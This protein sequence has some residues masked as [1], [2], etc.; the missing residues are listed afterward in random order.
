MT[1]MDTAAAQAFRD[2]TPR[3]RGVCGW[4]SCTVSSLVDAG[5]HVVALATVTAAQACH[6][7]PLTYHA[8]TFGTHTRVDASAGR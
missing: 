5:D 2:V 8:R 3:L 4:L 6:G 1:T 7:D